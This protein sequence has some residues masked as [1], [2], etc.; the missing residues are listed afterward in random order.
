MASIQ[1]RHLLIIFGIGTIV[2]S[3]LLIPSKGGWTF[4]MQDK[5]F[6]PGD[7]YYEHMYNQ[8]EPVLCRDCH[9]PGQALNNKTCTR[10][11]TS[12]SFIKSTPNLAQSHEL[13][14][15]EDNCLRCHTDHLGTQGLITKSAQ[16][17]EAHK[18]LP[19]QIKKT[20][21]IECH[22]HIGK[23]AHGTLTEKDCIT[24]HENWS[25]E[26]DFEHKKNLAKANSF[27][28]M[29]KLCQNCH[30]DGYHYTTG[31]L[32]KSRN[33]CIFCHYGWGQKLHGKPIP[34]PE[35]FIEDTIKDGDYDFGGVFDG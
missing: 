8:G 26:S 10:C 22:Q 3:L 16:T 15:K 34:F 7:I 35:K 23:E 33:L 31:K 20:K 29:T 32:E 9:K 19:A 30:E 14:N 12:E 1:M 11:H 21:C 5:L 27:K 24:C 28:G 4:Y 6:S 2:L 18:E 13:L 17:P 25:W